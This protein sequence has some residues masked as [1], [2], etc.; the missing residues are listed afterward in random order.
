MDTLKG[1]VDQIGFCHFIRKD[2]VRDPLIE[3]IMD[4]W[5][6]GEELNEEY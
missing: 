2:I 1:K 3:E 6:Q 4:A 5:Y